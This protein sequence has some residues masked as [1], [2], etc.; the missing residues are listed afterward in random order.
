[1]DGYLH[2]YRIV[3]TYPTGV[4]EICEKC[5]D[6]KFFHNKEPSHIYL[7]YHLRQALQLNN[8]RFNKEYSK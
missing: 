3:E 6:R 8:P 4:L 7:S 1:M 5:L 2:N